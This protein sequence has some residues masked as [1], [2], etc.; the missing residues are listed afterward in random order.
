M[1]PYS[2]LTLHRPS[3]VDDRGSL[4][5]IL[6][7]L[8]ELAM[9]QPIVFPVHPRTRKRLEEFDVWFQAGVD[10]THVNRKAKAPARPVEG[11]F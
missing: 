10:G 4:L 1:R 7:G 8:S 6:D 3:N 5:G 9:N 11:S 2:L